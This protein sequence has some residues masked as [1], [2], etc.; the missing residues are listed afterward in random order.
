MPL[1]LDESCID[2]LLRMEDLIDLMESTLEAY[3]SG[4][5]TQP[6]RTVIPMHHHESLLG[7][8]PAYLPVADALGVKIV[9]VAPGNASR[10]VP[11]HLATVFLHEA[12]TGRLLAILGARAVHV[13]QRNARHSRVRRAGA[14]PP[15]GLPARTPAAQGEGME[16]ARGAAPSLRARGVR[17]VGRAGRGGPHG[18]GGGARGGSRDHRDV[19]RHTGAAR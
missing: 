18:G 2:Q 9:T 8:M 4:N 1:L 14:Q 5:A 11:T 12:A 3:S 10:G 13:R 16:S 7:V 19:E 6:V 15:R 17:V